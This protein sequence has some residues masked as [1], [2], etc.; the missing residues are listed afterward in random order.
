M[1]P[2]M[3]GCRLYH[4]LKGV[5]E[6]KAWD[7][8]I[9]NE[10]SSN[11]FLIN[12]WYLCRFIKIQG[13]GYVCVFVPHFFLLLGLAQFDTYIRMCTFSLCTPKFF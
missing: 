12:I 8:F 1:L 13:L 7:T 4:C 6:N 3:L 10:D 9:C 2:W 11:T 5:K